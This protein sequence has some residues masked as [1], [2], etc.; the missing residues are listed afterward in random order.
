M[1]FYNAMLKEHD[2]SIILVD[3]ETLVL[4]ICS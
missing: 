4:N 2:I 1:A 3:Q